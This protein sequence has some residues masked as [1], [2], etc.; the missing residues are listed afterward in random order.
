MTRTVDTGGLTYMTF[1][2]EN[3]ITQVVGQFINDPKPGQ[4][5]YQATWDD[6][7]HLTPEVQEQILGA[8][9]P[10]ERDMR[11]R[12]I[13]MMGSGLVF[14]VDLETIMID[15]IAIPD[16]WAR[17]AAID[18]GWDHPTAVVWAAH[19]RDTDIVYIYDCYRASNV[20]PAVVVATGSK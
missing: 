14:P 4:A 18:F 17:I 6:A 16:Y 11:S 5:L 1:T 20:L 9:P 13:P 8:L 3:G 15:A 19:D 10:H 12:G 7:P 2:P